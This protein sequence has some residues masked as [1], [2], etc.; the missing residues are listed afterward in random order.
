MILK[1]GKMTGGISAI[2]SNRKLKTIPAYLITR[3]ETEET[4]FLVPVGKNIFFIQT[5]K[6]TRVKR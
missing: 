5:R 2:V 4:G 6:I 1:T 3:L